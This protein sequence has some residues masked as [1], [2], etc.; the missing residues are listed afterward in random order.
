[1]AKPKPPPRSKRR[2][3]LLDE[4]VR[5]ATGATI[6]AQVRDLIAGPLGLDM[7]IGVPEEVLPRVV[8]GRWDDAD[9]IA[10]GDEPPA[11]PGSYA[12]LR[13]QFLQ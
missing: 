1:M 12:A 11:P 4:I 6:A 3:S 8:P 7:W 2:E 10:P 5:R 9:P 13:H